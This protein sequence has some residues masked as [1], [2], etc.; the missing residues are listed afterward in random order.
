MIKLFQAIHCTILFSVISCAEITEIHDENLISDIQKI[1]K[2]AIVT[3]QF[4]FEKMN[5][6]FNAVEGMYFPK[7]LKK[8]FN[9]CIRNIDTT[10][11]LHF[12]KD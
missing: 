3:H 7:N 4:S 1:D 6:K 5:K 8:K 9:F 2:Y 12:R 10:T 11:N